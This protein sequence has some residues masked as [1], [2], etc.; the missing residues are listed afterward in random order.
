VE[1]AMAAMKIA[2]NAIP[3]ITGHFRLGLVTNRIL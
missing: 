1:Y 2:I 3:A